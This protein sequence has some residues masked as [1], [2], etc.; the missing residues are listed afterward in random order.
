MSGLTVAERL[1]ICEAVNH[2]A[3]DADASLPVSAEAH[4]YV[5]EVVS[6][7]V[8]EHDTRHADLKAIGHRVASGVLR[9]ENDIRADELDKTAA[10]VPYMSRWGVRTWLRERAEAYRAGGQS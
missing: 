6:R 4:G 3:K 10:E 8:A 1:A 5:W 7:I 2:A 9:D